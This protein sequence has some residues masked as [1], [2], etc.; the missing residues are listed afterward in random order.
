MR[1]LVLIALMSVS[2]SAFGGLT[3]HS[4]RQEEFLIEYAHEISKPLAK[5]SGENFRLTEQQLLLALFSTF[6]TVDV[7]GELQYENV[8][9]MKE[10]KFMRRAW[11]ACVPFLADY[12]NPGAAQMMCKR[13]TQDSLK[14]VAKR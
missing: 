9:G 14:R 11:D 5:W 7:N 1:F 3:P 13:F 12:I 6:A 4:Q 2:G 10:T 8:L